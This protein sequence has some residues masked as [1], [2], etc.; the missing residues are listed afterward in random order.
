M[1]IKNERPVL[2]FDPNCPLCL[3][4]QQALSRI[5]IENGIDF[6][7]IDDSD[8][9]RKHPYLDHNECKKTL[10]L[11]IHRER[12][13]K[14]PEVLDYLSRHIPVCRPFLW[15]IDSQKGQEALKYFY[16]KT[17]ELRNKVRR[18]CVQCP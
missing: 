7:A 16:D 11:L 6:V 9:F 3:R 12:I 18:G 13:L 8:F 2:L 5:Q 4:F 15:L 17:N 10:H 14:G 1:T